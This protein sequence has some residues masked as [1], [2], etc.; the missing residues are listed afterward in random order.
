MFHVELFAVSLLCL[1]ASVEAFTPN[2]TEYHAQ[3]TKLQVQPARTGEV[4]F[5]KCYEPTNWKNDAPRGSRWK[6]GKRLIMEVLGIREYITPELKD[7]LQIHHGSTIKLISIRSTDRGLYTCSIQTGPNEWSDMNQVY[8]NVQ[9][10]PTIVQSS[11]RRTVVK[12]GANVT[13]F[14]QWTANPRAEVTWYRGLPIPQGTECCSDPDVH[15][16]PASTIRTRKPRTSHLVLRDFRVEHVDEY[17]CRVKNNLGVASK[18]MGVL[19]QGVSPITMKPKNQ[20]VKEGTAFVL[21]HCRIITEAEFAK[22]TWLKNGRHLSLYPELQHRYK[23]F[24]NGTLLLLSIT[25][26]DVGL[27]TC[28]VDGESGAQQS[29]PLITYGRNH[30]G[31]LGNRESNDFTHF[32]HTKTQWTVSAKLDVHFQPDAQMTQ[33]QPIYLGFNGPGRLPCTITANPQVEFIEWEKV[34][35]LTTKTPP[36][37]YTLLRSSLDISVPDYADKAVQVWPVLIGANQLGNGK[38]PGSAEMTTTYWYEWDVVSWADN[39][40]YRCRGWNQRNQWGSWSNEITL[41][42]RQFPWFTLKPPA[43]LRLPIS[44]VILLRCAAEGDPRP[45]INWVELRKGTIVSE[46]PKSAVVTEKR[47]LRLRITE[48]MHTGLILYCVA[49]NSI[50]RVMSSVNVTVTYPA[51]ATGNQ[52]LYA[53]AELANLRIQPR[54]FGAWLIW[55]SKTQSLPSITEYDDDRGAHSMLATPSVETTSFLPT[56]ACYTVVYHRIVRN[57]E[58]WLSRLAPERPIGLK[59]HFTPPDYSQLKTGHK[60]SNVHGAWLTL[61]WIPQVLSRD[62]YPVP[63]LS[64]RVEFQLILSGVLA[65][66]DERCLILPFQNAINQWANLAPVRAPNHQFQFRAPAG[67]QSGNQTW[68][69][70]CFTKL[71]F[72]VRSYSLTNGSEPSSILYVSHPLLGQLLP[73]LLDTVVREQQTLR[74]LTDAST[75]DELVAEAAATYESIDSTLSKETTFDVPESIWYGLSYCFLAVLLLCLTAVAIYAVRRALR[76]PGKRLRVPECQDSEATFDIGQGGSN[77][78]NLTNQLGLTRLTVCTD[79]PENVNLYTDL[80]QRHCKETCLMHSPCSTPSWNNLRRVSQEYHCSPLASRSQTSRDSGS[81]ETHKTSGKA[82]SLFQPTVWTDTHNLWRPSY[83]TSSYSH[84]P[85]LPRIVKINQDGISVTETAGNLDLLSG[86][87]IRLAE[88]SSDKNI[89]FQSTIKKTS[90]LITNQSSHSTLPWIE[91]KEPALS[92]PVQPCQLDS[93]VANTHTAYMVLPVTPINSDLKP[94][95]L[96]IA[97][98][99]F[100]ADGFS[101]CTTVDNNSENPASSTPL[102]RSILGIPLEHP[103]DTGLH[104]R[105]AMRQGSS[106]RTNRS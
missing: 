2:G 4:A 57:Q 102:D 91:T 22:Y 87:K 10:A 103:P 28:L 11:A 60:N 88:I 50:G 8:L 6:F 96:Q 45:T 53:S 76:P 43:S 15:V 42:V 90:P 86:D 75:L 1:N 41:L 48:S 64:Y 23:I 5:L 16:M 51:P 7:R 19:V 69:E 106:V 65:D 27:Y 94:E 63:I 95:N 35:N 78:C 33:M 17:T 9:E 104:I 14:C 81:Y 37:N 47:Y 71:Y 3:F 21:F 67:G 12:P 80:E 36:N 59:L 26:F 100:G 56:S 66:S 20:T 105:A 55:D 40:V 77:K 85:T 54:S 79:A 72:R 32:H 29:D 97:Y 99:P 101:L 70:N 83:L 34:R 73:T 92:T 98:I 93:S 25:R 58:K 24:S 49:S 18:T 62:S 82:T 84:E 89:A 39:G 46:L 68:V 13:L 52:T 30:L 61:Q 38:T 74:N 44:S 31:Q